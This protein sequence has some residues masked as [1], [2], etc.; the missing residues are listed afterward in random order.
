MHKVHKPSKAERCNS[1]S[2]SESH[3]IQ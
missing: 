1:K 3:G 2:S